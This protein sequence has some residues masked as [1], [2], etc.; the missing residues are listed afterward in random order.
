MH[1]HREKLEIA[2]CQKFSGSR[3]YMQERNYMHT[4]M[5]MPADVSQTADKDIDHILLWDTIP[6]LNRSPNIG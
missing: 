3:N 2:A 5:A 4:C 1:S 6:L